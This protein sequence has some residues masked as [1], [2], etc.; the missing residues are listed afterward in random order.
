[1]YI[2]K[3]TCFKDE[4]SDGHVVGVD[5]KTGET[6]DPKLEGVWDNY[7]VHRHMLHSCSVIASNL[8]LVDEMMRAGRTSL[9][10][11]QLGE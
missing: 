3:L 7:R 6:M 1:M 8:L 10:G 9:K 4:H 11:P 5:L 2:I